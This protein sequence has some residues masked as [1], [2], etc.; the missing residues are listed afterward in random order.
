MADLVS[1]STPFATESK[2]APT[3]RRFL[4]SGTKYFDLN[5]LGAGFG[6]V[7]SAF[8]KARADRPFEIFYAVSLAIVASDISKLAKMF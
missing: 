3:G 2:A 8:A 6:F 4:E 7:L 5:V 1:A